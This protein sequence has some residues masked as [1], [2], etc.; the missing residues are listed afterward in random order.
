MKALLNNCIGIILLLNT[1]FTAQAQ[2]AN[3]PQELPNTSSFSSAQHSQHL[4]RKIDRSKTSLRFEPD[5]NK[6]NSS[7]ASCGTPNLSLFGS[8]NEWIYC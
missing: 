6:T 2:S 8:R 7:L 4:L 1:A 3:S 5:L